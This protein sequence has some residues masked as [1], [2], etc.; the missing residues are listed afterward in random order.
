MDAVPP[1]SSPP[2][3]AGIVDTQV[4]G[5]EASSRI[6]VS[7]VRAAD[8]AQGVISAHLSSREES[9][10]TTVDVDLEP[11]AS[12]NFHLYRVLTSGLEVEERGLSKETVTKAKDA[13]EKLK[14][15]V[16]TH[17]KSDSSD[18]T[19][20]DTPIDFIHV[21]VD[22]G[23]QT[24]TY[25]IGDGEKKTVDLSKDRTRYANYHEHMN[26]LNKIVGAETIRGTGNLAQFNE[27]VSGYRIGASAL[28]SID[29]GSARNHSKMEQYA[30]ELL[31]VLHADPGDEAKEAMCRLST[32]ETFR[33]GMQNFLNKE[34][35]RLSGKIDAGKQPG[36]TLDPKDEQTLRQVEELLVL[37]S[38]DQIDMLAVNT[39]LAQ[40]DQGVAEDLSSVDG[41]AKNLKTALTAVFAK[42]AEMDKTYKG[43]KNTL[44]RRPDKGITPEQK[45][46]M[47]AAGALALTPGDQ[48]L[49]QK[50]CDLHPGLDHTKHMGPEQFLI[51]RARGE[52]SPAMIG[53]FSHIKDQTFIDGLTQA[54]AAA[55]GL[56]KAQAEKIKNE[57]LDELP[58]MQEAVRAWLSARADAVA[59]PAPG[60][61]QAATPIERVAPVEDA[62]PGEVYLGGDDA[63]AMP[64]PVPPQPPQPSVPGTIRPEGPYVITQED[65]DML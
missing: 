48:L 21:Q 34:R 35:D 39:V 33:S 52:E 36:G 22:T 1:D 18:D 37:F 59:P 55:D 16:V 7:A 26:A 4:V 24:A 17:L 60:P 6:G 13:F 28:R 10:P 57:Q 44:L 15:L 45:Q 40:D 2:V 27:G 5:G 25:W 43:V 31:G 42:V 11:L 30:H 20:K 63:D 8:A 23:R 53:I 9:M 62:V 54:L 38:D 49:Y 64:P 61:A 41:H 65:I 58:S 32:A 46:Y 19:F 12:D 29:I 56:A 50:Y 51:A 3:Y 14:L 47:V